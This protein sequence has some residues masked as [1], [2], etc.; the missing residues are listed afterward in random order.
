MNRCTK[1]G[2]SASVPGISLLDTGVCNL[3]AR[4]DKNSESDE[5]VSYASTLQEEMKNRTGAGQ[6][7]AVAC[8]S[9]GK[10]STYALKVVVEN[11]GLRVLSFTL[12][13]GFLSRQALDNIGTVTSRLGVEHITVRPKQ[14]AY[15]DIVKAS[16]TKDVYNMQTLRRISS[17]CQSC[18]TIVLNTA[19]TIALEK[20]APYVIGGFTL[21]Q[22]PRG[23]FGYRLDAKQLNAMRRGVVEKFEELGV[24]ASRE[25][26]LIHPNHEINGTDVTLVNPLCAMEVEENEII[27]VAKSLGWESPNDVDGCSTNCR[28]NAVGNFFHEKRFGFNPYEV[29]LSHLVRRG[30]MEREEM[31]RKI[32]SRAVDARNEIMAELNLEH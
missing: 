8:L 23:K 18:I 30:L 24:H 12:D 19:V 20:G 14:D 27:R 29:E 10:D 6:Y 25:L 3:C 15:R 16:A 17:V 22:V 21:G 31:L 5:I 11:Y 4:D 1:C 13:N 28:L 9:G 26:L 2:I 32:S 7:D